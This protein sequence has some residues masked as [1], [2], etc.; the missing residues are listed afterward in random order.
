MKEEYEGEKANLAVVQ[1]CGFRDMG[2]AAEAQELIE[3]EGEPPLLYDE[4]GKVI[5]YQ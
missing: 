5:G 3:R 1:A 4:Q 2:E